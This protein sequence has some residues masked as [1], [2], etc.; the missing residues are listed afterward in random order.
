[1]VLSSRKPK[2][3]PDPVGQHDWVRAVL[4]RTYASDIDNRVVMLTD[5][6]RLSLGEPFCMQCGGP[7]PPT[8]PCRNG[9]DTTEEVQV[10]SSFERIETKAQPRMRGLT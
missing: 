3:L 4:Y 10:P 7:Y 9:D 5:A 2:A 1:M 6:T 8:G